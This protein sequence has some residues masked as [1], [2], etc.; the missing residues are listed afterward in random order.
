MD[1]V[2]IKV[3]MG[4]NLETKYTENVKFKHKK[5]AYNEEDTEYVYLTEDELTK[6]YALKINKKK[7]N[8]VTDLFIFGAWSGL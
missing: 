8:E 7:P 3:F 6:L 1:I 4:E 2:F 5:F